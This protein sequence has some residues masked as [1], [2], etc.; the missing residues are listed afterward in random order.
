MRHLLREVEILRGNRVVDDADAPMSP[1]A[2]GSASQVITRHLVTFRDV[3]ELQRKN[4]E[5]LHV[6]RELSDQQDQAEK[7]VSAAFL[8]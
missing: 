4:Q 5:L 7:E 2:D 3:E 6:V 1:D 8:V